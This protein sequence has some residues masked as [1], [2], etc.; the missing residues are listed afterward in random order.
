[1]TCADPTPGSL[2]IF[3]ISVQ[4]RIDHAEPKKRDKSRA[5]V[6]LSEFGYQYRVQKER[7]FSEDGRKAYATKTKE[8]LLEL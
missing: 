1:M 5:G 4:T 2:R 6:E 3:R 8:E 7:E